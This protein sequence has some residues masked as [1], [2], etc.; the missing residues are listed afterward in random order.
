MTYRELTNFK[1]RMKFI[2]V[3]SPAQNRCW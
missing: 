3:N 1:S 2:L